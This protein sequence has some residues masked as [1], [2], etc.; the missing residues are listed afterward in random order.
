[1]IFAALSALATV[2]GVG[3]SIFGTQSAANA[4][5]EAA[6]ANA[7]NLELQ[8]QA[9]E[10]E[11]HE[12]IVRQ[13]REA[14]RQLA[15][16]RATLADS[17][18]QINEGSNLDILGAAT[19]RLETRIA[20]YARQSTLETRNLRQ[21][22]ALQIYEGEQAR[23]AANIQTTSTLVSSFAKAGSTAYKFQQEGVF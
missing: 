10:A 23:T 8:A 18:S 4:T 17:G 11:T 7:K 16:Q 9:R 13:Q 22:A 5:Q 3:T 6:E 14:R 1:M 20:D 15:S 21:S 2:V 19:T 12:D